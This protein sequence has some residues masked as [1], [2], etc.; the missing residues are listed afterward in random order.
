MNTIIGKLKLKFVL[1]TIYS[2]ATQ[3]VLFGQSECQEVINVNSKAN[4]V[5]I[6]NIKSDSL[7]IK[8][9]TYV[10]KH[11]RKVQIKGLFQNN[12]KAGEWIYKPN[13][14]FKITGN[15][16]N[17]KKNGE[18]LYH[19]NNK[20]ISTLNYHNGKPEGKQIGYHENGNILSEVNY[21]NGKRNGEKKIYYSSGKLKEIAYYK[22]NLLQGENIQYTEDGQ[23]IS[24]LIY[25]N[26]TPISLVLTKG[27]ESFSNYKGSLKNGTGSIKTIKWINNKE[28]VIL[29]R[30]FKDSLLNGEITGYF[31]DGNKAF[32]GYYT[33]GF[34]TDKWTSYTPDGNP[35][36]Y[37]VYILSEKRKVDPLEPLTQNLNEKQFELE[38]M[39]KFGKFDQR[40]FQ[41][42]ITKTVR[43]P[44]TCLNNG[45]KGKVLVN[46]VINKEGMVE[47]VQILKSVHPLIDQAA[48]K[49]VLSSPLWTPAL[50][51]KIPKKVS[52]T[53]P[54]NFDFM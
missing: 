13:P 32:T 34:M 8:E 2:I 37:N 23:I 53:I 11:N 46:F 54:I 26:D 48:V 28:Q 39:P 12:K 35:Y 10:F 9:G 40:G 14:S 50:L 25:L 16:K 44:M 1:F 5:E 6:Y 7:N 33:S 27:L 24:K 18:W 45:V 47:N 42:F 41:Y 3:F 19:Q 31:P 15:Y 52:Y 21:I 49:A 51:H 17:N 36:R 20:L 30:N 43:Y 38:D 22:N 29:E 4:T